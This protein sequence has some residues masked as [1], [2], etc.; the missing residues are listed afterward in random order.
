M[1]ENFHI[2]IE[3]IVGAGKTTLCENLLKYFNEVE[4][5]INIITEPIDQWTGFGT[6]KINVLNLMYSSPEQY[7]YDFQHIA[8]ATKFDQLQNNNQP[9]IVERSMLSQSKVFIPILQQ[10]NY[11]ND[12]QAEILQYNIT[13]ALKSNNIKPDTI[14]YLQISPEKAL[15]RINNRKRPGEE[16]ISLHYLNQLHQ[17]HE[18]WLQNEKNLPVIIIN[19]DENFDCNKIKKIL[20]IN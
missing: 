8:I 14:I 4:K 11:I 5:N 9:K 6:N 10:N 7:A 19:A 20:E 18:I 12:F 1:K 17:Y 13:T 3:G 15:K 16:N 2:A